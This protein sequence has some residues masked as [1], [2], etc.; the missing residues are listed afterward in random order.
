[1]KIK[2]NIRGNEMKE[3][4]GHTLIGD[5]WDLMAGRRY[6][7]VATNWRKREFDAS[8]IVRMGKI[9]WVGNAVIRL[10][11]RLSDETLVQIAISHQAPE[12]QKILKKINRKFRV[13]SNF[14]RDPYG[15]IWKEEKDE[16]TV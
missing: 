10:V 7:Q 6:A 2:Q 1:M 8:E 3:L 14:G 5:S 13:G 11:F 9:R 15:I 12:T 16:R 4:N